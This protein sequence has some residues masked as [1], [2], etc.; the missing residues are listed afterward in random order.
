[1]SVEVQD[2]LDYSQK[3]ISAG[4]YVLRIVNPENGPPSL[5]KSSTVNTDFLLPNKVI[6]LARSFLEFDYAVPA[7]AGNYNIVFNGCLSEVDGLVLST[8]GGVRLVDENFL[9]YKTKLCWRMETDLDDFLTFPPH[10]TGT[11]TADTDLTV[12][13]VWEVGQKFHRARVLSNAA[14]ND[15]CAGGSIYFTAALDGTLA[16]SRDQYTSVSNFIYSTDTA[17]GG[18]DAGKAKVK[19]VRVKLPLRMI[20]GSLMALDKDL[21]FNE[22]LRLTVRWN[23]ATNWGFTS[24]A[25][26]TKFAGIAALDVPPAIS[27]VRL[28]VAVET[29]DAI[30]NALVQR[31]AGEG[32]QLKMPFTYAYRAQSS[33]NANDTNS[34]IR[35]LNRGHG[36]RCLRIYSGIFVPNQ[37]TWG[38]TQNSNVGA[39]ADAPCLWS[40]WRPYLDSKPL[41]DNALLVTDKTAY[42]FQQQ[43]MKGSVFKGEHEWMTA[44]VLCYDF[45]GVPLSKDFP[46]SDSMASGL[47]LSVEREFMFEW[48]NVQ[49][50]ATPLYMFAI[51]QKTLVI[52]PQGIQVL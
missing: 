12:P 21:Y 44:P 19:A 5:A 7:L 18:A 16:A 52:N 6:N 49:A 43:L 25:E 29:N 40:Q 23:Q 13:T 27:N 42:Q 47:D 45:S 2:A 31:V 33:A 28:R 24:T 26:E 11:S 17:H 35:K 36:E 37:A 48:V 39:T 51:C 50:A 9:P 1:M 8:A 3:E 15:G 38:F 4:S 34:V 20:Y 46:A 22:Q 32:I 10:P 30:S 41:T 14:S